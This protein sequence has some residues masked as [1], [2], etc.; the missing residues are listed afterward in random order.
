[1]FKLN[2]TSTFFGTVFS[3]AYS[4]NGAIGVGVENITNNLNLNYDSAKMSTTQNVYN[5][6]NLSTNFIKLGT[7]GVKAYTNSILR[8]EETTAEDLTGSNTY[9]FSIGRN[10]KDSNYYWSGSIQEVLLFS[11]DQSSNKATIE[12]NINTNYTIY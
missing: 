8:K 5:I 10:D 1:V 4:E 12:D 7:N 3:K 6:H 9:K 2:S 11:S